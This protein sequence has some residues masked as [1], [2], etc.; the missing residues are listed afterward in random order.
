MT[1][2]QNN[3]STYRVVVEKDR[4]MR[5][6]DGVTLYADIYRPDAPGRF[7][8]L[9]VRT[10]Y[11]KSQDM[12]LTEKDY[13][14]S[15]GY[16][17]VIQDTRGRFRSEGDFYP[18]IHETHDGYDT[19]EW[20]AALPWSNGNVGTVGQSYLG[21]VQY[22]A[23]PSR[24]PHLKAM[25][26]VSGPV[27]YFEN[28]VYRRGVFEL[29][30]M[31][32]YFTFMARNTLERKGVYE[33]HRAR[34][35]SYLSHPDL[36]ISPFKKEVYRHLPLR[37]WGERLKDGAPY[38]ADFLQH[39]TDGPY[40]W[41]TDLRRQFHNINVPMLHVGSWY[42]AF[43]YDTLTLFTGLREQA[44]TPEARRGQKLLM[45][46]WGH[47]LPYAVPTSR[48]TGDIDFGPEALIELHAVQLRWFDFF[49][50]GENNG[51]I[52]EAPIRLFVMGENRWRDE[53]EWPLA[54]THYTN[55][56]LH[57]GGKANTLR[58]NGHLSFVT[59]GEEPSD[60]YTYDPQDPV[61]T[62]GGTTLGLALGVFDQT[63][64]EERE[65]VLVYTS[66]LLTEAMEVTGPITLKLFASSSAPD[67]DFTAKL[68][69]VRPDG[70]AQ[71]IAE[72]VIRARFRE[73]LTNPTLITPEQVYA[74]T[75]DLWATSHVFKA[76][77][78]LRLEVSSSNFPR[79]DRNPNTG[80]D[81]GVDTELHP[82][83][84]TIF[85][86]GRYPSHLILPV[87]PR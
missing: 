49:L 62:R 40:W 28:C 76:G 52:D 18:F 35:D 33:Q 79:Y 64:I 29:G 8:V 68:V 34:L 54:R 15:R 53:Y 65:D 82:A 36:P 32:A 19:I 45:G 21:L 87:V 27:T 59:P 74:Y 56:Y 75:I 50:K 31:L 85:H 70:Y 17:V 4:A 6:R 44:L 43:Q 84:Q 51:V 48:G 24:P 77:H 23:A 41:A 14:P 80:R 1:T 26:P 38:F 42:D 63:K 22:L 25:S 66:D 47:L 3:E 61:P 67:T 10:P 73:S 7:P 58:G 2:T 46:P 57:S 78:R 16:V 20:A 39:A 83:Q 5:T 11:D 72:G 55:V 12:A 13:F 81:F 60:R 9:V 86:D 30:W 69:E 37:E 71:N